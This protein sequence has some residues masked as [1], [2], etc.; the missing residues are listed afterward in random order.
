MPTA[1]IINYGV[2]NLFSIS[3]SLRR[4]GF[5]VKI[6]ESPEANYDLIVFPGVGSFSAV[7]N[8]LLSFSE[9]LNDMRKSGIKFLGVCLGLQIFFDKGTE[10]GDTKGLSWFS[11]TVDKIRANVKLPHIGW[12]RIYEEKKTELS[13]GLDGRYAY[14]VHSYVAYTTESYIM[15]S[16]YGIE[17]PAMVEKDNVVGTQFHPEKSSETGKIFLENLMRWIKR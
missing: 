2:G 9:Q 5:E 8:F 11:G 7:S 15:K 1:L 4:V 3:S 12:D 14:F 13:E 17:F 6:K 10:G 16:Y